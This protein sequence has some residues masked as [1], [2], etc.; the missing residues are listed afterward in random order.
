[1]DDWKLKTSPVVRLERPSE[2]FVYFVC[3]FYRR[4]SRST[5]LV[6]N[7]TSNIVYYPLSWADSTAPI[8]SVWYN[9]HVSMCL[10]IVY[11]AILTYFALLLKFDVTFI[12]LYDIYMIF[13]IF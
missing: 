3:C 10:S 9:W 13:S 2:T 4:E 8:Y 5:Y 6:I 11:Y 1:M 7:L 12:H